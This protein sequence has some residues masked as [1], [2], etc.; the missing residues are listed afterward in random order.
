MTTQFQSPHLNPAYVDEANVARVKV[1]Q[2]V[3]ITAT[4]YPD[5]TFHGT[6]SQVAA[7]ATTTSNVTSF[8]V[9]VTL[10]SAAQQLLKVGTNTEVEFQVGQ[11][12][13]AILVPSAAIVRQQNDT[14]V[15]VVGQDKKPVFKS[16]QIGSTID[17]QTEVKAGLSK[18]DRVLISF[19]PGMEPKS[20]LRGLIG[21]V[22]GGKNSNNNSNKQSAGDNAPP[23]PAP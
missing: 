19:P 10:D 2:P 1:G 21:D 16:V 17:E 4:S 23:P 9:K 11:L 20:Q 5:R 3:K 13:N 18:D 22:T 7:Q 15:Y 14:G 6:V 8:E 12:N